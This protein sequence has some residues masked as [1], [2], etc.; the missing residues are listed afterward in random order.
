[1]HQPRQ[2]AREPRG[3]PRHDLRRQEDGLAQG[4]RHGAQR[5]ALPRRRG[6][7]PRGGARRGGAHRRGARRRG[8]LRRRRRGR[9]AADAQRPRAR[10]R[11]VRR[12]VRE[13]LLGGA[14]RRGHARGHH[15]AGPAPRRRR[16]RRHAAAAL[17]RRRRRGLRL[18]GRARLRRLQKR[19][20]RRRRR[21]GEGPLLA[22]HG[23][24]RPVRG[25]AARRR[26]RGRR[27]RR[28]RGRAPRRRDDVALGHEPHQRPAGRRGHRPE[29]LPLVRA[30]AAARPRRRPVA[31][32]MFER[33]FT[34]N[35]KRTR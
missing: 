24:P 21:G 29:R 23:G 7:R 26:G 5:D 20:R 10:L 11:P 1:M 16:L 27:R 33:F 25:A 3:P 9:R 8:R 34:G 31:A 17:R 30:H 13:S 12:R 19:A 22:L 2:V 35:T 4:G 14:P 6:R 18:H 15:L 28:G 32:T